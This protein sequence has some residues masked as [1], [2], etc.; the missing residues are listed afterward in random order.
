MRIILPVLLLV[1]ALAGAGGLY[2]LHGYLNSGERSAAVADADVGGASGGLFGFALK[3]QFD[4]LT[5]N[6]VIEAEGDLAPLVP[7][8]PDGWTVR[9]YVLADGTAITGKEVI[10][11]M[12]SKST[13]ND[14]LVDF[15]QAMAAKEAAIA[16][17]YEKGDRLI[18]MRI[19]ILDR[20]NERTFQGGIM[21]AVSANISSMDFSGQSDALPTGLFARLDGID[22]ILKPQFSRY[23]T[24]GPQEPVLYRRFVAKMEQAAV[25]EIITN[26][27]DA[28]IASVLQGFDMAQFQSMLPQQVRDYRPGVG[29]ILATDGELSTEPPGVTLAYRAYQVVNDGRI[30]PADETRLLEDIAEGD[31]LSWEDVRAGQYPDEP[32]ER[33]VDLLGPEPDSRKIRRIAGQLLA[34]HEYEGSMRSI[35]RDIESGRIATRADLFGSGYLRGLTMTTELRSLMNMMPVG[36]VGANVSLTSATPSAEPSVE[37]EGKP[38]VRRGIS[39]NNRDGIGANCTIELGVRR[40]II[41]NDG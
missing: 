17:T 6:V 16:V 8:A 34:E 26:A 14:I 13:T 4:V 27:A 12:V 24:G 20:L 39:T 5:G 23:T 36:E 30:Y 7:V 22:V 1:L 10:R 11:T 28:D 37:G 25:I 2:V 3:N 15:G 32:S 18:A 9:P 31:I 33:I 21:A 40:C 29:W 35:L 41:G 38:V 19:E